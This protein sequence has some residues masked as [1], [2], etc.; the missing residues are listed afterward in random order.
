MLRCGVVEEDM[1]GK[2]DQEADETPAQEEPGIAGVPADYP[3]NVCV[4]TDLPLDSM[5]EPVRYE[6]QGRVVYFCCPPCQNRFDADPQ[7]Y[8]E[9]LD[10]AQ[11]NRD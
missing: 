10:A 5:G 6:Y 1:L 2:D 7:K 11:G 8:L 4:V 9:K 3:L